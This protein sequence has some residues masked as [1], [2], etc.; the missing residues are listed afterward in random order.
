MF[1]RVC[2]SVCVCVCRDGS[3]VY[4]K[5]TCSYRESDSRVRPFGSDGTNC[6]S[7]K[8]EHPVCETSLITVISIIIK[9]YC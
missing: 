2:G 1:A 8:M 6:F 7:Y 3:P 4:L 9:F 5:I